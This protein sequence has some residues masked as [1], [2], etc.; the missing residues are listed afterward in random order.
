M[1]TNRKKV[2]AVET[3]IETAAVEE[4]VTQSSTEKPVR[5]NRGAFNGTRGKLQVG[6]LIQGYHLYFFNDEPGR[7][8]A[9]LDAGWEFVSPEEVG[10]TSS[11]VTNR[12]VDLG[13]R[14]SVVGSKNDMGQPV[15]QVLLKIKQ[16]W[17]EEDQAEIQQRNDKTDASIR[18]GKG[19]QGV[20][21]TGF[22]N[23]GIKY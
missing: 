18:R 13:G 20:D 4:T 3:N 10:Y 21:T 2:A 16:E 7:I 11:N 1:T 15:Q 12:N 19:G 5:R 14:V 23:A 22:Y 6:N 17:W 9:A 8:Q